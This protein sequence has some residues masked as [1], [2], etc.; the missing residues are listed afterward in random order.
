MSATWPLVPLGDVLTHRK[1]FVRID[2]LESY[3]RCRVQLH[4][5][6]IVLRDVVPGAQIKTKAQQVCR[7]GEFLVAEID[8]KLGG[9]GIVPE[10]LAGA[11]VSSHYFLFVVND[12]C[13]DQRFLSYFIRTA[14]F[15]DQVNAQGSTNYAAIRPEDVLRYTMPLP[16]LPEQR[17]I[18]AR[19][20]ALAGRIGEAKK[21]REDAAEEAARLIERA[22]RDSFPSAGDRR[23]RDYLTIQSG[24]A[25]KS[26]WFS[27]DGIRLVRNVNVGHGKLVWDQTARLPE[28]MRG[29][30]PRFE[31]K[32]GDILISLDRPIISS[33]VKVARV[34][35]DDMPSLLLQRVGRV[36]FVNDHVLPDYFFAWL[37]S[38]HFTSAIDPGRSNGV[39][40][41][42]PLDVERISFTAPPLEEQHRVVKR[43]RALGAQAEAVRGL[44]AD[45]AAELDALFPAVL[46]Q[47][48][49]GNF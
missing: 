6:G 13:L 38:P 2:D 4:A 30:F 41:I 32:E 11:I 42:S 47:A 21:L 34:S 45:T 20:E 25:F 19:I 48:F 14:A 44:Q 22:V 43:L 9:F 35:A 29:S 49:A 36:Q 24:Y 17:R 23:V 16:P 5:Q 1:E 10:D 37:Q 27:E 33:G 28:A 26:E 31:I 46:S 7:A 3:K 39:P 8:A 15:R 40:H 12:A 18:V